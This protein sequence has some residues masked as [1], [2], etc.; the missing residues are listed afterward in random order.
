MVLR[1]EP[2]VEVYPDPG[3]GPIGEDMRFN[4][5]DNTFLPTFYING[6]PALDYTIGPKLRAYSDNNQYSVSLIDT[7]YTCLYSTPAHRPDVAA[8]KRAVSIGQIT[9][10][11]DPIQSEIDD[12]A[13]FRYYP[14]VDLRPRPTFRKPNKGKRVKVG[15]PIAPSEQ[16]NIITMRCS[17]IIIKTKRQCRKTI[18]GPPV[19]FPWC[20]TCEGTRDGKPAV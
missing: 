20:G 8:L 14:R 6:A 13:D 5:N 7:I 17:L 9:S 2:L 10:M 12:P 4:V 16:L 11:A 3:P 15:Q 18:R 1:D 19:R